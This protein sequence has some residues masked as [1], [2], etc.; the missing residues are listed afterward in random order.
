MVILP[1]RQPGKIYLLIRVSTGMRRNEGRAG[2]RLA[3]I[4]DKNMNRALTT[5]LRLDIPVS[6][7]INPDIY[8]IE[9][10]TILLIPESQ[11]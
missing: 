2:V 3:E 10:T 6:F 9:T 8:R 1:E 4:A 7:L 11:F 5:C